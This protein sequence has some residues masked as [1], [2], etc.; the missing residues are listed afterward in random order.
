VGVADPDLRRHAAHVRQRGA[1]RI[2]YVQ[3]GGPCQS[4]P[5][6]ARLG[7]VRTVPTR[8]ELAS[9]P[10]RAGPRASSEVQAQPTRLIIVPG[11]PTARRAYN[12]ILCL[13]DKNIL[14]ICI[15]GFKSYLL[16]LNIYLHTH[17]QQKH[18]FLVFY[19][20][21]VSCPC[22]ATAYNNTHVNYIS[23]TFN[24]FY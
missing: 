11:Q 9:G 12:N 2:T 13:N 20:L 8:P 4:G 23:K 16:A 19:T 7:T 17:N 1:G 15:L 3:T 22:V 24:I 5:S 14:K 6:T 18:V 21:L 10:C